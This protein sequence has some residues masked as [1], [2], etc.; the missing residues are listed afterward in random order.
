MWAQRD[1]IEHLS[2]FDKDFLHWGYYIGLNYNDFKVSY[3]AP[4]EFPDAYVE[5]QPRLGFNI[6]L[7]GELR[8]HNNF[9]LRLEPGL[10]SNKKKLY[11][12][13]METPRDSVRSANSAYLHVPLLVQFN[14]DRMRNIR[15]FVAAGIAYDYNFASNYNNPDDN[16]SGEFRMQ[17]HNLMYELAVGMDFYFF[18]FKFSPSIR[19]VFAINDEIRPDSDPDSPWTTPVGYFGTRGVFFRMTFQ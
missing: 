3:K 1:K 9:S 17:R 12:R 6:G 18:Y 10:M 14:A 2:N 7:I 4:D 8:L 11:F 19:G 5:T 13:H 16:S 15:P